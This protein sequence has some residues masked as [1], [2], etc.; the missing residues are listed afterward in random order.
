M[1]RDQLKPI[2]AQNKVEG[3]PAKPVVT[4][5]F[6][7]RRSGNLLL[8]DDYTLV[9][10]GGGGDCFYA[11]MLDQ[12]FCN[13]GEQKN[14]LRAAM[15]QYLLHNKINFPQEFMVLD[16]ERP[17]SVEDYA[18]RISLTGE[19]AGNVEIAIMARLTQHDIV[20][21]STDQG[22]TRTIRVDDSGRSQ[23]RFPTYNIAHHFEEQHYQSVH[24]PAWTTCQSRLQ[25]ITQPSVKRT[26]CL[27]VLASQPPVGLQRTV[28]AEVASADKK[29]SIN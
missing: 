27:K 4:N 10:V 7:G 5:Q 14:Y 21:H 17:M 3:L 12:I 2:A 24:S 11:S 15:A 13:G 25:I 16:D 23:Q 19:Y 1:T 9:E 6:I 29:A 20:V 8:H 18:S 22:V 28:S 26:I